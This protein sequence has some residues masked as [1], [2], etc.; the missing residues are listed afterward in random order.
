MAVVSLGHHK[1][2]PV[3]VLAVS[4]NVPFLQGHQSYAIGYTPVTSF[5]LNHLF[6]DAVSKYSHV[7]KDW[8][9]DF[10]VRTLEDAVQPVTQVK[11]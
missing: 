5:S 6:R 3:D 10:S 9:E 7:L 11:D 2:L 4:P 8:S 1:V